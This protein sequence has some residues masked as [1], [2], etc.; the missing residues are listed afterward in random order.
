MRGHWDFLEQ[1]GYLESAGWT[2]PDA[3]EALPALAPL[4]S[5]GAWSLSGR[6]ARDFLQ[7]YVAS[8]LTAINDTTWS[9]TCF[10]SIKGRV[11]ASALVSGD[12]SQIR[13]VMRVD[14]IDPLLDSLK[15]FLAFARDCRL[16]RDATNVFGWMGELPEGVRMQPVNLPARSPLGVLSLASDEAEP[17]WNRL[18]ALASRA[19]E[20]M[21]RRYEIQAG[22]TQ[23][24]PELSEAFLPQMLGLD[25]LGAVSFSKG[26]YLGQEVVTRAAHRGVVKRRLVRLEI[27]TACA[28]PIA[29][30][31]RLNNETGSEVGV[32]IASIPA[33]IGGTEHMG[34]AVVNRDPGTSLHVAGGKQRAVLVPDPRL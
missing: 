34:L 7:G 22:F 14:M 33:A 15:K 13:F 10:C 17:Y 1:Y 9:A 31:T 8:D 4:P 32:L 28:R 25:R 19:D 29:P 30:G 2:L 16:D 3:Q 6:G 27:H 23:I 5:L 18:R 24:T 20:R 12:A 11:R 26:C 21:W